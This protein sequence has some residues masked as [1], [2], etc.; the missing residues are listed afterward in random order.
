M[1]TQTKP[2]FDFGTVVRVEA[3]LFSRALD[4]TLSAATGSGVVC[5]VKPPKGG[6]IQTPT[7]I[8]LAFGVYAADIVGTVAGQWFYRFTSTSPV[9]TQEG[10]FVVQGSNVV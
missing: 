2:D 8:T 5:T 10:S 9:A 6:A 3:D 1:T 4:G 7:V